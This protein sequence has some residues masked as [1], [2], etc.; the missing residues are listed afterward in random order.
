[1][2]YAVIPINGNGEERSV[3]E[4]HIRYWQA[5]CQCC[6]RSR[7]AE[8]DNGDVLCFEKGGVDKVTHRA[9]SRTRS[10]FHRYHFGI[11]HTAAPN[12][13]LHTFEACSFGNQGLL[14]KRETACLLQKAM[15]SSPP[16]GQAVPIMGTGCLSLAQYVSTL[17]GLRM[18]HPAPPLPPS[19]PTRP[20]MS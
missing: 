8:G 18:E 19:F 6:K 2:K 12:V 3:C 11:T 15:L 17:P 9:T 4:R 14:N 13:I 10:S 16:Q 7:L 1:M 20:D 5:C